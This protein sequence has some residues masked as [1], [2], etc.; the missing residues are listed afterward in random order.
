MLRLEV[1][2]LGWR[3]SALSL[4]R[5]VISRPRT[6]GLGD[7]ICRDLRS[8]PGHGLNSDG[9]FVD[10]FSCEVGN[11]LDLRGMRTRVLALFS[12]FFF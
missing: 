4:I 1:L 11:S 12:E 8:G 2:S 7:W 6:F 10:L 5:V 9:A 3:D